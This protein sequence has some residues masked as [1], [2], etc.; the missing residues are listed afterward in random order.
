ML[1]PAVGT[2]RSSGSNDF[3]DG[4]AD[5]SYDF[6]ETPAACVFRTGLP[7]VYFF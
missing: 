2:I 6:R 1:P 3:R 7:T 5:E 4:F